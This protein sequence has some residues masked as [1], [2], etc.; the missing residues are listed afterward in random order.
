MHRPL[1]LVEAK[2]LAIENLELVGL[3][4]SVLYLYPAEISGG[5][6]KRV[7]LARQIAPDPKIL[8]L[9]NQLRG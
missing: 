1:T 4:E 9:M 8:F 3:D 5:M 6:Q 7:A 2:K